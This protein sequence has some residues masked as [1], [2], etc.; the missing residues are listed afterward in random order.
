[1]ML[2]IV[3]QDVAIAAQS[4]WRPSRIISLGY[5]KLIVVRWG[6]GLLHMDATSGWGW[7]STESHVNSGKHPSA[8]KLKYIPSSS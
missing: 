7:A 4:C 2:S 3:G 5:P 1:M 8:P 6:Q